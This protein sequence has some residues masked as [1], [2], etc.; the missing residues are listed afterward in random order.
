[1]NISPISFTAKIPV[2]QTNI[3]DLEKNKYE[4]ATM[5]EYDCKDE[6]DFEEVRAFKGDIDL[7]DS[8]CVRMFT[9]SY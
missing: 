1:M 3:V 2:G 5:F 8:V 4:S 6:S 9:K 7:T